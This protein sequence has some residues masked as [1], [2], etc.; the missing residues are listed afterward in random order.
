MT[1]TEKLA[2]AIAKMRGSLQPACHFLSV[3]RIVAV[4]ECEPSP[5]RDVVIKQVDKMLSQC[6]SLCCEYDNLRALM[7]RL[8]RE[9]GVETPRFWCGEINQTGKPAHCQMKL[10]DEITTWKQEK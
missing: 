1:S 8:E 5:A 9:G 3:I 7:A 2:I 6:Q 10:P 4:D